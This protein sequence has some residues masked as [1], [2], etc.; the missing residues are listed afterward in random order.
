MVIASAAEAV[1]E[2]A[3]RELALAV[4]IAFVLTMATAGV[5]VWAL[6]RAGRLPSPMALVVALSLLSML[7]LGAFVFTNNESLLTITATGVGALAGAVSTQFRRP[8]DDT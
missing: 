7:A 1:D 3:V 8:D 4:V 6:L 2:V 5:V